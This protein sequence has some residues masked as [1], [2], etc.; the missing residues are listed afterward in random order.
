MNV[1]RVA[2]ALARQGDRVSLAVVRAGGRYVERVSPDVQVTSLLPRSWLG[3]T[4]LS[5]LR[6]VPALRSLVRDERPDVL[7]PVMDHCAVAALIAVRGLRPG[8]RVVLSIQNNPWAKAEHGGMIT[9]LTLRAA[10][11]V[12]PWA[13]GVIALSHGVA[14]ALRDVHPQLAGR[15]RVIHNA[16]YDTDIELR[17]KE[18]MPEALPTAPLI[19]AVGRL[20]PQK[21]YPLLLTAFRRVADAMP[22]HLWIVGEGVERDSL[23]LLARQLGLAE[24]VRFLGARDNPYPY[25]A[26]A[27][28][29]VLSSRWEGFGNVLTEAM[30][31]GTPVV[32]TDC[33]FGPGEIIDGGATGLLVPSGDAERLADALLS[34]LSDPGLAATLGERGR[35]RAERF[36]P[37]LIAAEWRSELGALFTPA[38]GG[39]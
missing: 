31:L 28:V 9:R 25:M 2:N 22:V 37:D 24:R 32:S 7:V 34:L 23:D 5:L 6:S 30:T 20:V 26:A 16:G 15:V 3:S 8:P 13:D 1:V 12:Y 38:E 29:F 11:R 19:V 17:A 14:S 27:D 21:D 18:S 39:R 4:T 35:A 36:A 10:R 33:P